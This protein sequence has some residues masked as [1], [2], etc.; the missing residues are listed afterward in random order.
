MGKTLYCQACIMF[1]GRMLYG[2]SKRWEKLSPP[3]GSEKQSLPF[4]RL[5]LQG[6]GNLQQ[7]R[8][9][10]LETLL[11]SF[12]KTK[13]RFLGSRKCWLGTIASWLTPS[14]CQAGRAGGHCSWYPR[15]GFGANSRRWELRVK[16]LVYTLENS[17]PR[18]VISS[19]LV[20]VETV[21]KAKFLRLK[22]QMEVK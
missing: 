7:I 21:L 3:G 22:W 5:A 4:V 10:A 18:A 11:L 20:T 9:I 12:C 16:G 19:K 15:A 17:I 8:N 1:Y 13:D 14:V 6:C 2:K